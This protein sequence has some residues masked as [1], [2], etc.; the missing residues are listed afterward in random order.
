MNDYPIK[1]IKKDFQFIEINLG[2]KGSRTKRIA[3]S[4]NKELSIF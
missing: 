4:Q 3:L 1:K 2:L